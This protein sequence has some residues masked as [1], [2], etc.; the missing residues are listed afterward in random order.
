MTDGRELILVE[1]RYRFSEKPVSP[2][3]SITRGKRLRLARAARHF[4]KVSPDFAEMPMRFD[5]LA[6]S[7]PLAQARLEWIQGAFEFDDGVH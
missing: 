6:L 3:E 7:G 2:A 1:V 4:L 5:L